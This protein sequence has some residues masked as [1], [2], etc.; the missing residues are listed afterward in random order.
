MNISGKKIN[1][2]D[3]IA[4]TL[5]T[6]LPAVY[7]NGTEV[8][9]TAGRISLQDIKSL[10]GGGGGG[11]GGG[12]IQS[13]SWYDNN[14]GTELT[15]M[16]MP[17]TTVVNVYKN[18]VLLREGADNDYTVAGNVITFS[19]SLEATDTICVI[20]GD[21]GMQ[22]NLGDLSGAVVELSNIITAGKKQ[23]ANSLISKGVTDIKYTDSLSKMADAIDAL[24][25]NGVGGVDPNFP[26]VYL[27]T[28]YFT[29][30]DVGKLKTGW[31]YT[32][33]RSNG[34]YDWRF[35]DNLSFSDVELQFESTAPAF[36]ITSTQILS[37][38]GI[39]DTDTKLRGLVNKS[40]G[41]IVLIA[42]QLNKIVKAVI[43]YST[44][45]ITSASALN[46]TWQE[47][48]YVQ[49]IYGSKEPQI[50]TINEDSTKMVFSADR[51]SSNSNKAFVLADLTNGSCY[52]PEG[53]MATGY[54]TPTLDRISEVT[55]GLCFWYRNSNPY[56]QYIHV[57]WENFEASILGSINYP[58]DYANYMYKMIYDEIN[59]KVYCT[60]APNSSYG[61]V[62]KIYDISTKTLSE[63]VLVSGEVLNDAIV[64][65][66]LGSAFKSNSTS[67]DS[68]AI[69]SWTTSGCIYNIP[70]TN[71]RLFI[72]S[73][74][75]VLDENDNIVPYYKG[76]NN[77]CLCPGII[78]SNNNFASS[79]GTT[80]YLSG[81][82]FEVHNGALYAISGG[83]S[84]STPFMTQKVFI[85][86]NKVFYFINSMNGKKIAYMNGTSAMSTDNLADG[87]PFDANTISLPVDI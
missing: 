11:G 6:V 85:R 30:R 49:G 54:D 78:D 86:Y 45:T 18:G 33:T 38:A 65:T 60:L 77:L 68:Y 58:T 73:C 22:L 84:S 7:V 25:T 80:L 53:V 39:T 48:S 4:P 69:D 3:S 70:N 26:M 8:S 66:K 46:I 67:T 5:Q 64:S 83:Y 27:K 15:I 17:D 16:D 10:I 57:N 51:G 72:T 35:I 43:N 79:G 32:Y 2:L 75:F 1:E 40:N 19:I 74:M 28:S 81:I 42:P 87:G 47:N 52:T 20:M 76:M 55:H 21:P 23:I 56:C 50:L 82:K 62:L 59:N 63:K 24:D 44:G 36:S 37:A 41:D 61:L 9:E 12:G 29:S 71:Y 13:I 34:V 31:Y 14:V